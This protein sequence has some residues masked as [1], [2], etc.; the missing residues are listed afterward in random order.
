MGVMGLREKH[1]DRIVPHVSWIT[2]L[3][4]L[5]PPHNVITCFQPCSLAWFIRLICNGWTDHQIHGLREN[6]PSRDSVINHSYRRINIFPLT[7][8]RKNE[9]KTIRKYRCCDA[10][11]R[12]LPFLSRVSSVQPSA[13][14]YESW[15]VWTQTT[16]KKWREKDAPTCSLC[17]CSSGSIFL[18]LAASCSSNRRKAQFHLQ[19]E[20]SCIE[21][22]RQRHCSVTGSHVDKGGEGWLMQGNK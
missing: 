10:H 4:G 19:G 7:F 12:C 9:R 1:C 17:F 21:V 22:K 14:T 3:S 11:G 15:T 8:L 6:I 13:G 2:F 16:M 5:L 18:F 20:R